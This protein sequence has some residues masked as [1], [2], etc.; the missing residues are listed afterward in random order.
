MRTL[1]AIML[2]A[3]VLA[4][5]NC[6]G[7]QAFPPV[8]PQARLV[9][10]KEYTLVYWDVEL[11]ALLDPQGAYKPFVENLIAEFCADNPGIT[12]KN[13]WLRWSGAEGQLAR[14]LRDGNPPDLWADWQ[15][16]ARR[17]H[18]LQV[19]AGLWLDSEQLTPAGKGGGSH[20]GVIWA[21]PRWIWPGGLLT[22]RSTLG[23]S[24]GELEKLVCSR[25]DWDELG[26]WLQ[27]SDLYMEV[28]DWQGQF[29]AQVLM[30]ATGSA[31][32]HWGGQELEG[33]FSGARLLA[34]EGRLAGT[35]EYRKL[36]GGKYIIGGFPPTL[37]TWLAENLS[38]EEVVLLPLPGS[39]AIP[40]AGAN[41]V[42]FRQ[43][44]YLGD[45]HTRAAAMLAEFL[46]ERQSKELAATL[47]AAPAW[48]GTWD[49]G[50]LPSWY[51]QVLEDAR[52][53][54]EPIYPVDCQGREKEMVLRFRASPVLADFWRG[55]AAAEDVARRLE[56]LQ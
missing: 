35:G 24:P 39:A 43:I 29:T 37:V 2:G 18:V 8:N 21:W 52:E 14:A 7:S 30:A 34:A 26:G 12:V 23:L 46:A 40:S 17:D 10:E 36:T 50:N 42:Q 28:N 25:W 15:G 56:E 13:E 1:T 41:L 49:G 45:D 6:S 44:K 11:P 5:T 19:P 48:K 38:E 33:Y 9:P 47:W 16:L 55:K 51:L 27:Q 54:G 4:V 32:G 20:G 3:L 53:R 31:F 22:L